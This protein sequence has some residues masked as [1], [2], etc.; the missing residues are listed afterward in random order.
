MVVRDRT[1]RSIGGLFVAFLALMLLLAACGGGATTPPTPTTAA[2]EEATDTV[3]TDVDETATEEATEEVTEEAT[4]EVTEGATEETTEE[5]TPDASVEEDATETSEGT[6]GTTSGD[7][8]PVAISEET[9]Q[10]FGGGPVGGAFQTFANAMALIMQ[11]QYEYLDI[12]A[13]GTGGSAANLRG[14][15]EGDFAYGIVYAGDVF[16]GQEGALPEDATQYTNVRP[17]APLYGGV[18][19]LVVTADSG[20]ETVDDLAGARIALG[21]AGSGAALAAERYFAHMGLLDQ[22]Q[23]EFLGYTQAAQAMGDGQLDG[24]WILAALPNSSVT[25]ASTYTDIKLIDVYTP[26][27]EAGFFDEYPFYTQR[28]IPG[29]MYP[30]NDEA[31]SAFQDAALLVANQDVSADLVYNTMIALYSDEGLEEM[32][33][34]HPAASEMSRENGVTGIPTTLHPGAARYWEAIGVTIPEE[35]MPAQE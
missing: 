15:N 19:Q 33:V 8:E 4:E 13:E 18:V 17:M 7:L 6:E 1:Y 27:A 25:E 12:A 14:V 29:G 20:I 9:R 21:N 11:E 35:I 10:A 3:G 30:G 22:M 28:D 5:A 31:I 2:V 24:F 16:L 34:A 32:R 23:I 26:G